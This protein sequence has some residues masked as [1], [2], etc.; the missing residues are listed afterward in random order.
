MDRIEDHLSGMS[1][2]QIEKSEEVSRF[3][4]GIA[5]KHPQIGSIWLV[6]ADGRPRS[7]NF[8]H[9]SART[10]SLADR[11]YMQAFRSGQRGLFVGETV[12]G[13][14]SGRPAFNIARPKLLKDGT[15]DGAVVLAA[16]PSYFARFYEQVA[17]ALNHSAGLVRSDGIFLVRD[18]VA[19]ASVDQH[20]AVRRQVI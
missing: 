5:S 11:D 2:D 13:K 20:R 7:T 16:H 6:D 17:L 12:I 4:I 14:I 19:K 1:W 15:L 10:I 3:L 9:A 8:H 18:A